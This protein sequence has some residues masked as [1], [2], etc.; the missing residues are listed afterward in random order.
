MG[1]HLKLKRTND[2][3]LKMARCQI[4]PEELSCTHWI[5]LSQIYTPSWKTWSYPFSPGGLWPEK[6]PHIRA[7]CLFVFF[8][9]RIMHVMHTLKGV[10]IK[11][12]RKRVQ[13]KKSWY[14]YRVKIGAENPWYPHLECVLLLEWN[15]F[16]RYVSKICGHSCLMG[17]KAFHTK[18]FWCRLIFSDV[19]FE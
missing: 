8:T 1:I 9:M 10:K 4:F 6:N 17:P 14:L 19:T 3:L 13:F 12:S 15:P 11:L 2:I 5:L 18:G 16:F 7:F